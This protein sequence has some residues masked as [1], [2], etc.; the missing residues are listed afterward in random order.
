M[1]AYKDAIKK[2]ALERYNHYMSG[3]M[4]PTYSGGDM[5]AFIFDV[6]NKKVAQ[7]VTK[8]YNKLWKKQK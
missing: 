3:A 8:E 1:R 5:V 2:M 7:D 4:L 6:T